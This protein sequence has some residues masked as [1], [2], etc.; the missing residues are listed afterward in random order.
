MRFEEATLQMFARH[1]TF[2]LRH[3][4]LRKAYFSVKDASQTGNVFNADDA[5]VVLGVGKNMVRSIRFWALAAKVLDEQPNIANA[6]LNDASTTRFGNELF[7]WWDPFLEDPAS[8]WLLHWKLLAPKCHLPVWWSLLTEFNALEFTEDDAV[9]FVSRRVELSSFESPNVSSIRKDVN[10]FLRSYAPAAERQ[11]RAGIDDSFDCQFRELGL[12]RRGVNPRTY[13]FNFGP[14][15][16]LPPA[17]VA[18]A[19]LQHAAQGAMAQTFS[20]ARL[21]ADTGG[22]GQIFKLPESALY[23][24]LNAASES[25]A[26][27]SVGVTNGAPQLIWN[28]DAAAIA[29]QILNRYYDTPN[30]PIERLK[31]RSHEGLVGSQA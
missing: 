20:I 22:P 1:E 13:R 29:D 23:D 28:G 25:N 12:V 24:A 31:R 17:I 4:W 10:I 18:F 26:E 21:T 3:G 9:D 15:S 5:T 19:C 14:K 2:H 30:D 16:S 8:H 27:I 6:R 7:E 11:A